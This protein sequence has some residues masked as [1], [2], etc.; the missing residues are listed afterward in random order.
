MAR[1]IR[2][3]KLNASARRPSTRSAKVR[4]TKGK[5]MLWILVLVL[6]VA[7]IY[8]LVRFVRT[9]HSDGGIEVVVGSRLMAYIAA[10]NTDG[11]DTVTS[12]L[13]EVAVRPAAMQMVILTGPDLNVAMPAS[14]LDALYL[15]A[16]EKGFMLTDN[17]GADLGTIRRIY[18]PID[19]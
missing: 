6:A 10:E 16:G 8:A 13:E 15:I 12:A 7:G 1:R 9:D 17:T 18:I 11:A 5:V 4:R 3:A 19:E 2:I 14:D